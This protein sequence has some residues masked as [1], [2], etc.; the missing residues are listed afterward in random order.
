[1]IVIS[2]QHF[3]SY[4]YTLCKLTEINVAPSIAYDHINY[5]QTIKIQSNY[6]SKCNSVIIMHVFKSTYSGCYPCIAFSK[7]N[8]NNIM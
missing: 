4:F 8:C 3:N 6:I 2:I 7:F 5:D 1:M